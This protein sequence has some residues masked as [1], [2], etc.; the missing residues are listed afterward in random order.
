MLLTALSEIKPSSTKR[1]GRSPET[2]WPTTIDGLKL[3][4]ILRSVAL[5]FPVFSSVEDMEV[6]Y[7]EP[8][9]YFPKEIREKYFSGTDEEDDE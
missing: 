6:L 4:S 2:T 5:S 8:E 1:N 3:N 9:D 7:V